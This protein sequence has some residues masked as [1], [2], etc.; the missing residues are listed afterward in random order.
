LIYFDDYENKYLEDDYILSRETKLE[1]LE[2]I[3]RKDL[4][5][6]DFINNINIFD[7]IK[8]KLRIKNQNDLNIWYELVNKDII[9]KLI[10]LL[11]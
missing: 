7:Y 8:D 2:I 10:Q 11:L 3:R 6:K 4:I 1:S 5:Q 9:D